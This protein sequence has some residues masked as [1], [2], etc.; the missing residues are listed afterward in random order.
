MDLH[1]LWQNI[2]KENTLS[3][4]LKRIEETNAVTSLL[5]KRGTFVVDDTIGVSLLFAALFRKKPANYAIITSNLYNA[6]NI[7]D[8]LGSF[9]GDDNVLL[10]PNDDLLRS[11]TITSSKELMAQRLYVMGELRKSKGKILVAHMSSLM[12]FMPSP[13]LFGS[14]SFT[15]KVGQEVDLISI[16]EKLTK[17]GYSRVGKIDQSMQYASRGDILDIFSVNYL[18]PIRI[19][20]FGDEIESIRFFDIASQ[21]SN[22][23]ISEITITPANDILFT[24]EEIGRLEIN[25][26]EQISK[27][28]MMLTAEDK[29]TLLEI[30][31][32]DFERIKSQLIHPRNY[33][34]YGYAQREHYSILDYAEFELVFAVNKDALMTSQELLLNESQMFLEELSSAGKIITHLEIYQRWDNVFKGKRKALFSKK[35]VENANDIEFKVRPILSSS[36]SYANIVPTIQSYLATNE[37][38]VLALANKQQLETAVSILKDETMGFDVVEA[39]NLPKGK[40]GVTLYDINEGFELV[41]EKICYLSSKELLG[42]KTHRSRF[43]SRFKESTILKSFEELES[44]DYVVHEYNGIG[45]FIDILTLEI[46]GNKRDFLHIA[47]AGTDALYVPLS[48]FRLIRKYA[49]KEGAAPKLSR[50]GGTEWEKTKLRIKNRVNE[51]AERLVALYKERIQT[52]GFMFKKDEEIQKMFEEEFPFELTLDQQEALDE[53]KRDMEKPEVMDRLLCGDVGFGKTEVAFRAAFKAIAN[54]KQAAILCPTTLLARQHYERAIERFSNF[55]VRIAVF[56]RLI[57]DSK[58]RHFAELVANGEVDLVIGTHRLLSKDIVFKDLGLLIIDEEQRFGVEQKERIKELK[59]NVDVLTLSATPIPRTLQISLLGI[60]QLSQINT[61][62]INRMPIQT[63]VMQYREDVI[64]ELIER[65]LARDG[66]V[67]Y[68]H[69]KV[70]TIYQTANRIQRKITN[71]KIGVVHGQMDRDEIEDVMMNFYSGNLNILVA[72]SIIEN[73]IDIA[74]AN[75]I[76][77]EDADRFGLSQLYQIKGRVGR[78]SRIAYAYLFYREYKTINEKALKRLKAIQDFTELGS[79]YKIAQRDLMIRGAGDILG[80]EQAGFIDSVGIDLYLKMLS[81]AIE[82]KKTGKPTE[83]AKA[84]HLFNIEAYIP[85]NYA[86]KKD[87]IELYQDIESAKTISALK[88]VI[89]RMRDIYG[90]IPREVDAL[91]RQKRI[92]LLS[93]GKSFSGIIELS[94]EIII[95]LSRDF[96]SIN[97]IGNSLFEKITP[98]LAKVKVSY[99]QRTLKIR[100]RKTGEWINDLEEVLM[101][102]TEL[103]NDSVK[104]HKGL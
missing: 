80:P 68:V 3:E 47:Y 73:G 34:Y 27:D 93:N 91:I 33:K 17:G 49:G 89:E 81:E 64:K 10:F 11:E 53:I 23:P 75:L 100:M 76:I 51:L 48:Q 12:R 36:T 62:P 96:S 55:G 78:G 22:E 5:A 63:Y 45:Q 67:F 29:D 90:R 83:E 102:I 66:Q 99:I 65:E 37:K 35:Y 19:E 14:L 86:E 71:A 50:L 8:L 59:T 98:Y 84:A 85:A 25:L 7:Y 42:Y 72:T 44:G 77:I 9:L 26:Q 101:I 1:P 38:I 58:Q 4:L 28:A 46:D 97:G 69:N 41:E 60:R 82:E 43:M 70:S 32:E 39:L 74:N 21:T 20:F 61:A 95:E 104:T 31:K 24:S 30:V 79:G 13:E 2:T 54:G 18:R 40:L 56:S 52:P 88:K 16:R 92:D 57:P 94:E 103:Y 87:K 6:Q 15:L